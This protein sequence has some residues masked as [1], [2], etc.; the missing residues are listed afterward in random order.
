MGI[1]HEL[2]NIG[3]F[4]SSIYQMCIPKKYWLIIKNMYKGMIQ[5]I[6]YFFYMNF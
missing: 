2:T 1:T 6:I 4:F 5:T 3:M